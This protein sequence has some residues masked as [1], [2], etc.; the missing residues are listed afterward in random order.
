MKNIKRIA[1][2]LLAACLL[3]TGVPYTASA[4]AAD[5]TLDFSTLYTKVTSWDD[6]DGE[7]DKDIPEVASNTLS[8]YDQGALDI[9][10][11]DHTPKL[12]GKLFSGKGVRTYSGAGTYIA[13]KLRKDSTNTGDYTVQLMHDVSARGGYVDLH[14]LPVDTADIPGSLSS[15]NRVGRVDFNSLNDITNP[16]DAAN[17]SIKDTVGYWNFGSETEFLVVFN[18]V[19]N[20]PLFD[21]QS[22]TFIETLT[23][24]P[25]TDTV[26]TPLRRI[27]P[28]LVSGNAVEYFET[29]V[30]AAV[31]KAVNDHYYLYLPIEGDRMNVYDLETQEKVDEVV[32]PFDVC[33]GITVDDD[34]IVWMVGSNPVVFSYDPF[35][36][37]TVQYDS[38]K[39][40]GLSEHAESGYYAHNTKNYVFFGTSSDSQIIRFNKTNHGYKVYPNNGVTFCDDAAYACGVA[41]TADEKLVYCGMAGDKN[42]DGIETFEILKV[43]V[44]TSAVEGRADL[45]KLFATSE[46]MFR[47]MGLSSDEKTLFAG[48]SGCRGMACINTETMTPFI[49]TDANGNYAYNK[50]NYDVTKDPETGITYLCLGTTGADYL[51]GTTYGVKDSH[52]LAAGLYKWVEEDGYTVNGVETNGYLE[53]VS[54]KFNKALKCGQN[55]FATVGGDRCIVTNDTTGVLYYNLDTDAIVRLNDLVD[56]EHDGAPILLQTL[57]TDDAGNLYV[58]SF[59]TS[60]CRKFD[61]TTGQLTDAFFTSGQTDSLIW[62]KGE[63]YAGNYNTGRLT[64][65][66]FESTDEGKYNDYLIG[67]K[68]HD[69]MDSEM[70]NSPTQGTLYDFHQS[71]VHTLTAGDNMVFMGT[72]PDQYLFGG[73]IGWY[74]VETGE[75]FGT[76]FPDANGDGISDNALVNQSVVKLVYDESTNLL[77]GITSIAGGTGAPVRTASAS[78][79]AKLFVYDVDSKQV[80]LETNLVSELSAKG[81]SLPYQKALG[82]LAMDPNGD[83]LWCIAGD[84]LLDFTF[85][86][87]TNAITVNSVADYGDGTLLGG[88]RAKDMVFDDEYIY[89]AFAGSGGVWQIRR[90]DISQG[91]RLPVSVGVYYAIGG[92]GNLYYTQAEKLYMYPLNVTAED[93]DAANAVS[94]T[95]AALPVGDSITLNTQAAIT[96]AQK[97]YDALSTTQRALVKNQYVLQEAQVE[98]LERKIAAIDST[99]DAQQLQSLM[100]QYQAL[101][102]AD[103]KKIAN[104]NVLDSAYSAVYDD[105]YTVNGTAYWNIEDAIAAASQLSGSNKLVQLIRNTALDELL[106]TDGVTL[107]LNGF[108]LTLN[109]FNANVEG[110]AEG[111]VVDSSVGNNGLL[112]IARGE[113]MFRKNNPD[114]PVYDAQAGGYRFFDYKLE[115]HSQTTNISLGKEK[116]WFKFHFYTDDTCAVLDQDAYEMV[117][118]DGSNLQ[119]ST[120][121]TWNDIALDRVY[122]GMKDGSGVLSTDIFAQQWADGATINRWLYLNVG[123]LNKVGFGVLN[124]KPII[125][126]NNVEVTNGV[127]TYEK[128]MADPEYG[129][130]EGGPYAN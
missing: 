117:R 26:V 39:I 116:F 127:I 106:L 57:E 53:L 25:G 98:L 73:A 60:K 74:N 119:I 51:T 103:K 37:K 6:T 65:V 109:A 83:K 105:A 110:V 82:S 122:F 85:D 3:L 34:G 114:L 99:T 21:T 41:V 7:G 47:G 61:I 107:D 124:V 126:V 104:F 63:L 72:I 49:P 91:T 33:R 92:D 54:T 59:N 10:I 14:I 28:W 31:G 90:S 108:T 32:T 78:L 27:D 123:G 111:Y 113:D 84:Y 40:T 128:K 115:L 88:H 50:I 22:Y 2:L 56:K 86:K 17:D 18:M 120:D 5:F 118:A 93:Q 42:E 101:S 1:A 71:R 46:V 38:Y 62:Y 12:G 67:M 77:Y 4:A 35:T 48:A 23:F 20:A 66:N 13:F 80:L 58:G 24:I 125:T 55:S 19:E 87:T 129:W 81:Y 76:R 29:V 95:I 75:T 70:A 44:S 64:R 94:N 96:A 11:V 45:T 100:D 79:N 130:S 69:A 68:Y 16:D 102:T 112:Q 9:A 97:A 36:G 15:S 89:A 8:L 30:Y 43:N 52:L 121:L